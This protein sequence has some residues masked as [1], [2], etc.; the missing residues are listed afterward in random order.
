M[1]IPSCEAPHSEGDPSQNKNDSQ[2]TFNGGEIINTQVQ[3][4]NQD[5]KGQFV[6]NMCGEM[7]SR[8]NTEE[9][10]EDQMMDIDFFR[11]END[12]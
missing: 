3:I 4:M 8:I 2:L 7:E 5:I 9:A 1:Q 12:A 11:N 6:P 10:E